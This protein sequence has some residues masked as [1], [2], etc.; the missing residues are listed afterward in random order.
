[1]Y[2]WLSALTK[3]T[4][5]TYYFSINEYKYRVFG[6]HEESSGQL[7]FMVEIKGKYIYW[8]MLRGLF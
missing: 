4:E 3:L 5:I 7:M 1:M 6:I 2:S 8:K